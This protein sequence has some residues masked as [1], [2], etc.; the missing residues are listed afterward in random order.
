MRITCCAFSF[1]W[2]ALLQDGAAAAQSVQTEMQHFLHGPCISALLWWWLDAARRSCHSS[3]DGLHHT[4]VR[5]GWEAA[6]A[7][8]SSSCRTKDQEDVW[9]GNWRNT[10]CP[11]IFAS[12]SAEIWVSSYYDVLCTLSFVILCIFSL[13]L[14]MKY[15]EWK[16]SN[17]VIEE[18][19]AITFHCWTRRHYSYFI[20]FKY[21]CKTSF[22]EPPDLHVLCFTVIM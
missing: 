8:G 16:W 10:S 6:E 7:E 4:Q 19:F 11:L 13:W 15:S 14:H 3:T 12:A 21:C 22:S 5:R 1:M 9:W 20:V 18:Q 17:Y 2:L